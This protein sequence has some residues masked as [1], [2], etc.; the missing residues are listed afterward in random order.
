MG[1]GW[2]M[3]SGNAGRSWIRLDITGDF[4]QSVHFPTAST[5]YICGSS[6]T[7]LKTTDGGQ[8]WRNIRKGGS[9]GRRQKP[10]R[11]LWFA[12]ADQGWIVGDKG[13]FWQTDD[14]GN[15]WNPV[16]DAP[17]D[18]DFNHIFLLGNRGWATAKAG[19]LFSF[20]F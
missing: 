15:S 7:V 9:T 3:R 11:A 14:G 16:A 10:F 8:N 6:G 17:S 2:V 18:A 4:F 19:R 1:F 12:S 13:I 20:E 5:G